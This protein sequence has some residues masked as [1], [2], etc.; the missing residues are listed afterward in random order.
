M[1]LKLVYNWNL[2]L[3]HQLPSDF[4]IRLSYVGSR[5]IHERR[6]WDFNPAVGSAAASTKTTHARRLFAPYYA[7]GLTGY[8]DNGVA[9]YN[10][11]QASLLKRYSHGFTIQMNYTFSKSIDDIGSGLQGNGGDSVLPWY[12]P[13]YDTMLKGPSDFDHAHRIVTSYVWDV[14]FANYMK[15]LTKGVLGG[16]Q[17]T[18][19]QQ[20]QTGSPMTVNSGVDNSRSNIGRDRADLEAIAAAARRVS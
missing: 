11:L 5:G 1:H 18:G 4:S 8:N 9:R 20:Y 13:F 19:I 17:L 14:P 12:S 10:S 6:A 7:S 2:T 16:W 3:E 15:G